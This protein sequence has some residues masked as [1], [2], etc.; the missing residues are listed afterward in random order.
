M[1][2]LSQKTDTKEIKTAAEEEA[3]AGQK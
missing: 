3:A 2:A 1:S